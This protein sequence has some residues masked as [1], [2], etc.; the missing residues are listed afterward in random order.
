MAICTR[1]ATSSSYGYSDLTYLDM[2]NELDAC[3]GRVPVLPVR[4]ATGT[5]SY[6]LTAV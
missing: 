1:F 3:E 5:V 4:R 2:E 6:Q